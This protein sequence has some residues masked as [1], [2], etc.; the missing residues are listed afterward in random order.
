MVTSSE[1]ERA[2]SLL[3]DR[4]SIGSSALSCAIGSEQAVGSH[5]RCWHESDYQ[6]RPT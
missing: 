5:F 3:L 6:R 4:L 1:V 2:D